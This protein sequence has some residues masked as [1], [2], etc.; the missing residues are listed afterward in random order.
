MQASP[1]H[2][3]NHRNNPAQMSLKI[4]WRI[5]LWI[6]LNPPDFVVLIHG[7]KRSEPRALLELLLGHNWMNNELFQFEMRHSRIN[8]NVMITNVKLVCHAIIS[9]CCMMNNIRKGF[10][11]GRRLSKIIRR[12]N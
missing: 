4:G 1:T 7:E 9:K 6:L 10:P 3:Y 5:F 8:S 12:S 11:L 2:V